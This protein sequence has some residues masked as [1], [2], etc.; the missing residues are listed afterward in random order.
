[1]ISPCVDCGGQCCKMNESEKENGGKRFIP[2][3]IRDLKRNIPPKLICKDDDKKYSMKVD[4]IGCL[5]QDR[6][7]NRCRVYK[8]RPLYCR[9]YPFEPIIVRI[10]NDENVIWEDKELNLKI[11]NP[12]LFRKLGETSEILELYSETNPIYLGMML[13]ACSYSQKL[14]P[15]EKSKGI[16]DSIKIVESD[17]ELFV[18]CAHERTYWINTLRK[19]RD[20]GKILGFAILSDIPLYNNL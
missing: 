18:R 5:G 15:D 8:E 17:S 14:I 11:N 6:E 10:P 4:E 3:T 12:S 7:T 16:E 19:L 1:M 2:I 13:K 9:L 20:D